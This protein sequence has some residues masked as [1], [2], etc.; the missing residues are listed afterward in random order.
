MSVSPT[1]SRRSNEE[2]ALT[3]EKLERVSEPLGAKLEFFPFFF[4]LPAEI[5]SSRPIL[6]FECMRYITVPHTGSDELSC[7]FCDCVLPFYHL[8]SEILDL[9]SDDR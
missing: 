2:V 1:L 3:D 7:F 5:Q 9:I 8:M 6:L 4:V